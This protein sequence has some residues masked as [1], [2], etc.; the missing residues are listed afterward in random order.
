MSRIHL[1]DLRKGHIGRRVALALGAVAFAVAPIFVGSNVT[2]MGIL[3]EAVIYSLVVVSLNLLVGFG[4]LVSIGQAGFLAIGAYAA[5]Y[6]ANHLHLALP[7]EL[8]LAGALAGIVGFVLGLPSGRLTGHY[9][10]IVTL[11]FGLVVPQIALQATDITNGFTGLTI[12]NTQFGPIVMNSTT[13]MYYFS[14]VV[15]AISIVLILSVLSSRTGRAIMAMRD[16]EAA[17]LAMGIPV[18]RTKVVLFVLSAFFCGIAGDL[19]AHFE[20]LVTPADFTLSLSLFFLAA[21]IV[22]G[23]GRVGGSILGALVL[24]YVQTRSASIGVY[25]EFII[26]AAVVV[27]LM[28]FPDGLAAIPAVLAQ[29][30]HLTRVAGEALDPSSPGAGDAAAINDSSDANEPDQGGANAG[31]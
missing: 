26:G 15:V 17:A 12:S 31:V 9:L 4:G 5:G 21:V 28:L 6:S 23:L 7:I 25:S 2:T 14:F 19:F 18:A 10:V 13:A 22:G 24:V 11:G 16:S 1:A 29:R 8:L 20:G 3:T 27:V 30:L